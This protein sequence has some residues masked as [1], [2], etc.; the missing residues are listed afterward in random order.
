MSLSIRVRRRLNFK[1]EQTKFGVW[2]QFKHSPFVVFLT[3]NKEAWLRGMGRLMKLE[4]AS[5]TMSSDDF[6]RTQRFWNAKQLLEK[7][8][9]KQF[10]SFEQYSPI[11]CH[12]SSALF[13]YQWSSG[14]GVG[15]GGKGEG[16]RWPQGV[17]N[18][19]GDP[20][21]QEKVFNSI[22]VLTHSLENSLKAY[23]VPSIILEKLTRVLAL[24][25]HTLSLQSM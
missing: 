9:I 8:T 18:L 6:A 7:P 11:I 15:G 25:F 19:T 24:K 2:V 12:V 20:Q 14:M 17:Y 10:R 1:T 4:L 21:M 22:K 5:D 3:A 16:Y 13:K 23:W